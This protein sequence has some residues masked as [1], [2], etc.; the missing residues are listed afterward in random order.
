[1]HDPRVL[2]DMGDEAVRRLARRGYSLNLSSLESLWTRR[3]QSIRTADELRAESKRIAQDVQRTAKAGGDISALKDTA[4]KLKEQ[5]RE[6]EAEQEQVQ[7]ELTRF[8]LSIPNLPSDE[9][10]D[11]DSEE[12][13]VEQRRIGSPP[14]FPFEPK[15]HVDL[16]DSMGILDF[17]RATKALRAPLQCSAVVDEQLAHLVDIDPAEVW[18][19]IDAEPGDLSDLLDVAD[20]VAAA[21]GAVNAREKAVISELR[22]RCRRN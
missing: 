9:A 5:S 20:R 7:E 6:V 11:G 2:I 10:P 21:D 22:E 16:G 8:L 17:G 19:R 4:R 15:D 14:D 18:R 3:N 13:A 1:M 12:F